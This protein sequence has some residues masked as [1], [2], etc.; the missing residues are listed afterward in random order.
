MAACGGTACK[1]NHSRQSWKMNLIQETWR[2]EWKRLSLL[3]RKLDPG[4]QGFIYQ[5]SLDDWIRRKYACYKWAYMRFDIRLARPDSFTW[6]CLVG[7]VQHEHLCR[8]GTLLTWQDVVDFLPKRLNINGIAE[9]HELYKFSR[10]IHCDGETDTQTTFALHLQSCEFVGPRVSNTNWYVK[11]W[12]STSTYPEWFRFCYC[13]S[14]RVR[15]YIVL[16]WGR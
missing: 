16:S 12:K 4:I 2:S 14:S 15:H 11:Y 8:V 3:P 10:T 6:T 9:L 7:L 5:K 13:K 1:I